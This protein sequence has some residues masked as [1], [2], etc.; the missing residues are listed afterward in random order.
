MKKIILSL[1]IVFSP[2]SQAEIYQYVD[3]NGRTVFTNNPPQHT[4]LK[5][6]ELREK[7]AENQRVLCADLAEELANKEYQRRKVTNDINREFYLDSQ[8]RLI[9]EDIAQSCESQASV[10]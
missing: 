9:K 8:I 5:D 1:L 6:K 3:E 2:I 4:G 10:Q 7:D